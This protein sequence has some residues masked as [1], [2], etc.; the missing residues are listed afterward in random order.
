LYLTS[1]AYWQFKNYKD[2][3]TSAGDRSEGFYNN[4]GSLQVQKIKALTRTYV[5][6]AQG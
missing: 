2:L 5:K 4:D 6:A 1:W 3:T